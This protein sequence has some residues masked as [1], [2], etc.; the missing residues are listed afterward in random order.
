MAHQL[1]IKRHRT[2]VLD[3]YNLLL[4]V[5]CGSSSLQTIPSSQQTKPSISWLFLTVR[6][7]I[8][9]PT[10]IDHPFLACAYVTFS[11]TNIICL[12]SKAEVHVCFLV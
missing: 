4:P 3:R 8:A 5:V 11:P 2:D 6:S 1:K 10:T 7:S 12:C 9:I